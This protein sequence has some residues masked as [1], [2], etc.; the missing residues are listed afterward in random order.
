MSDGEGM[1][2][3]EKS[4]KRWKKSLKRRERRGRRRGFKGFRAEGAVTLYG[5]VLYCINCM[6]CKVSAAV[7]YSRSAG[8]KPST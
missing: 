7:L 2:M 4:E 1:E 8:E 6:Y 3:F 5:T